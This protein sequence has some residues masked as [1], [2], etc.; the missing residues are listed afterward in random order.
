M[1]ANLSFQNVAKIKASAYLE[2]DS[3]PFFIHFQSTQNDD[4]GDHYSRGELC[5]HI[6]DKVLA[7]ALVE[8]INRVVDEHEAN[9][10]AAQW[11]AA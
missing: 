1:Y 8:A 7:A 11:E 9:L 4:R 5:L 2:L 10:Q 3:T 6:R